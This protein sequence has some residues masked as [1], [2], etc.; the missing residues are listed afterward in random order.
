VLSPATA[1]K[2]RQ[3][4]SLL[5]RLAREK[6]SAEQEA[7]A[8]TR[9]AEHLAEFNAELRTFIVRAEQERDEAR[10]HRDEAGE[11]AQAVCLLNASNVAK[12]IRAEQEIARL[13]DVLIEYAEA[14]MKYTPRSDPAIERYRKSSLQIFELGRTLAAAAGAEEPK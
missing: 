6:A 13:H 4:A 14:R 7:D 1:E 5:A 3:A 2:V 9:I 12:L 10:R 11:A 8:A